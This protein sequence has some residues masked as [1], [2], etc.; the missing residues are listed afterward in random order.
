MKRA[1]GLAV[2]LALLVPLAALGALAPACKGSAATVPEDTSCS[3]PCPASKIL[4]LIV[5]IQENHT[6]DDHFGRYCTAPAGSAPSCTQGP[7]C[8]ESMPATDPS[9]AGPTPL[10]DTANGGY[11][12]P[13]D[14]ACEA[15]EIDQGKMDGFVTAP[16]GCGSAGN[17][18]AGDPATLQPLWGLAS[19][20]AL[21][22]R[23]FQPVVGQ[24]YAN[25]MYLARAQYVFADD[26][27]APEGAVGVTCG[28]ESTQKTLT[29][30]TIADLLTTAGVPWAFYAEGY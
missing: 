7:A 17:F 27:V 3:G 15:A 24:S 6:F 5:V 19:G 30:T 1:L 13:H 12:P 2:P 26:T 18:A 20:G 21:A 25:D 10:D 22:D 16:N 29:G 23:Y 8:C 14:S 9:G 28:L 4:H 11:D